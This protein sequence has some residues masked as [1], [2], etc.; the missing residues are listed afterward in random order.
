LSGE[1]DPENDNKKQ[2]YV[3]PYVQ[4]VSEITA[5]LVNKKVFTVGFR[6]L[7]KMNKYI[8][9]QKDT[10]DL[11][12]KNN[13]VYKKLQELRSDVYR[14]NEETIKNKDQRTS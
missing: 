11:T 4:G 5:S 13:I 9:V 2:F 1:T 10:T 12:Q 7:N 8:K 6:I 14:T 3:I